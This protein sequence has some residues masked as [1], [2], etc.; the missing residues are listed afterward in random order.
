MTS[1]M[2]ADNVTGQTAGTGGRAFTVRAVVV[3]LV[4][5][6]TVAAAGYFN[7]W[8]LWQPFVASDL[9]PVSAYGLLLAAM[10][11]VNPLL[12]AARI[13]PLSA[14]EW[15]VILAMLLAACALPGPG[16]FW[17]FTN[18]MVALPRYE[19]QN[20]AWQYW[21]LMDYVP[22]AMQASRDPPSASIPDTSVL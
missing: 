10:L 19:P 13:R 3:G 4:L 8:V 6:G 7:D 9:A 12:R 11:T 14:G 17:G 2:P 21:H 18:P 1:P 16:L 15:C 5:G 20:P 22:E